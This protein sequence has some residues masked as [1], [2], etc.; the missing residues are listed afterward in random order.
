M[1]YQLKI[2]R[3]DVVLWRAVLD[4]EPVVQR[5]VV[6]RHPEDV[7]DAEH[8]VVVI[9]VLFVVDIALVV[10][11]GVLDVEGCALPHALAVVHGVVMVIVKETAR[12]VQLLVEMIALVVVVVLV[13]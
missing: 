5:V 7:A 10:V 9:V 11:M 2:L 1:Y 13:H 6:Q 3:K 4:V 12:D 8:L